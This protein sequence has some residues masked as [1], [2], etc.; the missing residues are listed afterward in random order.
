MINSRL[1]PSKIETCESIDG[2][3]DDV[4]CEIWEGNEKP[5]EEISVG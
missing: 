4:L 3:H 5:S 1:V 2:F